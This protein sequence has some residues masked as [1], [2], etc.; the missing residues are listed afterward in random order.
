M[1]EIKNK[2]SVLLSI[3]KRKGGE[4]VLTK[5]INNNNKS[6]FL[7]QV[8]SLRGNEE[9]LLCF[10]QDELNWLLLTSNRVLEEKEGVRLSIAF[11]ELVEVNL[12]MQEEFKDQIMK[13]EDFTRLVLKDSNGREY[14]IKSERGK[15]YQGIYQVL[16]HIASS[17]KTLI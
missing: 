2:S 7:N 12:A 5:I 17:N 8:V 13:K 3:F 9:P 6:D 14:I 4:G 1:E 16:H 15:P 10:K 11:S